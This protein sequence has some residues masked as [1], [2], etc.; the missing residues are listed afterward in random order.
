[1][2]VTKTHYKTKGVG[3]KDLDDF[4]KD[5]AKLAREG[6]PDG[7]AMFKQANFRVAEHIRVRAVARAAGVGPQSLKAAQTLTASKG[8]HARLTLGRAS[9]PFAEGAEFGAG[10]TIRANVG[11]RNGPNRGL[12]WLQFRDRQGN[13]LEWNEPGHGQTGHFLFPTMRAE[14]AAIKEMYVRDLNDICK[15]AFPYGRL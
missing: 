4:R 7:L 10:I 15:V 3:I 12:G 8:T 13:R 1:M 14:S 6:G 9:V 5:L 11:G 2:A